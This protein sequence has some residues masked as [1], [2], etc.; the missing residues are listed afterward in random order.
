MRVFSL[1]VALGLVLLFLLPTAVLALDDPDYISINAVYVFADVLHE[2][3]QLYFVRYNVTYNTTPSESANEAWQLSLYKSDGLLYEVMELNYYGHNIISIYLFPARALVWNDSHRLRIMQQPH[4]A[5]NLTEGVN[6]VTRTLSSADYY[7]GTSLGTAMLVEAAILQDSWGITLLTDYGRLNYTGAKFF[8]D[9]VPELHNMAPEIFGDL[10]ISQ[11]DTEY[12]E[13]D[14]TYRIGLSS[15]AGTRLSGAVSE[16]GGLIGV[17]S[18][19]MSFWLIMIV[20]ITL[21]GLIFAGAGTPGWA[22]VAGFSIIALG[23]YLFGGSLFTFAL[24]LTLVVGVIFGIYFILSR[25]A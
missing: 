1:A 11:I 5:D 16:L 18:T 23:G 24:V 6:M 25:L 19:W 17:P 10:V 3:D 15:N 12:K 8:V 21:A 22:F 4:L 14:D 20:F 13:Y 9:G 7:A 2:G